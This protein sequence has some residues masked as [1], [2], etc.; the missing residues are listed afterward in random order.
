[1][2]I[3]GAIDK[4]SRITG[5]TYDWT[6]EYI[7]NHGGEDGYFIRK[8]DVGLIAQE[9]EKILPEIVVERADGYKAIK[10]ERVVALLV[11][12]IKELKLD[13]DTEVVNLKK[14]IQDLS[15]K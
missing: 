4:V 13:L 8:R 1:M 14:K 2:P 7:K 9:I 11:E 15:S 12:A 6:D 10:Y 5:V 3:P